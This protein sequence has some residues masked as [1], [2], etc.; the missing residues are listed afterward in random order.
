MAS[1]N[2]FAAAAPQL[3]TKMR[4]RFDAH[5]H[6]TLATLRRDGAPRISGTET[7]FEDGELWIGS[8]W[9]ALKAFD[10]R[11]DPRFALHSGS[12]DPPDWRG[13]AKLEGLAEEIADEE[14][15]LRRNGPAVHPSHLFRLE[16]LAASFV[17][18]TEDGKGVRIESWTS[19]RGV[20]TL[21]RT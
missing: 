8:M 21:E 11:R 5:T 13:D 1:W 17:A 20:R 19:E 2:E 9:E 3:A 10:L 6:K 4:E 14:E 7:N 16:I 15:V 18:L 12:D